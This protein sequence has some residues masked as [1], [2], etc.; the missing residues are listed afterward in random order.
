MTSGKK[1]AESVCITIQR[2][3]SERDADGRWLL[4]YEQIAERLDV[5]KRVV[6]DVVRQACRSWFHVS[7][8]R[9]D[10]C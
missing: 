4:S 3:A 9:D 5:D 7:R 1:T 8:W 10:N 2:L 6:S